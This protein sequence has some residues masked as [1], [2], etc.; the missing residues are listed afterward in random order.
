V[1][2][3]RKAF[4]CAYA[5]PSVDSL[6]TH[7]RDAHRIAK[8]MLRKDGSSMH[9]YNTSSVMT[10]CVPD[11]DKSLH[12]FYLTKKVCLPVAFNYGALREKSLNNICTL[13]YSIPQL[14]VTNLY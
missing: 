14:P 12:H 8:C 2:L 13:T 3:P 1:S 7:I 5:G 11:S 4:K 9:V 10:E 6:R